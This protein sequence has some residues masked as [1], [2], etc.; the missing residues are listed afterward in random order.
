MEYTTRLRSVLIC[1][2]GEHFPARSLVYSVHN[3]RRIVSL[4]WNLR[5]LQLAKKHTPL[6]LRIHP[7]D[8]S[9]RYL[10]LIKPLS[11]RWFRKDPTTTVDW[12]GINEL[13]TFR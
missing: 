12:I 6:R 9:S 4:I 1:G 5:L 13:L 10:G 8:Y 3:W 2:P 11:V 7:P